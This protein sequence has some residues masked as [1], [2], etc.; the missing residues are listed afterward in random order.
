MKG[1]V[2][3][4]ELPRM[5]ALNFVLRDALDGGAT[6]TLTLDGYGKV[7]SSVLLSLEVEVPEE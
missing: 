2:R 1:E 6:R 4:Y 7:L 5:G 3:R